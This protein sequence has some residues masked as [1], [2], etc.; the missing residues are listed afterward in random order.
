MTY[1][2]YLIGSKARGDDN[3]NSDIDYVCIYENKKPSLNIAGGSISY[4]SLS[5]MKWMIENSKLFVLHLIHEGEPLVEIEAHTE[6]LKKFSLNISILKNDHSE[7]VHAIQSLKWI[8][9]GPLG[10]R[11]G[12]DYAYTLARNIIFIENSIEGFY[13]FGYSTAVRYFLERKSL[14]HL[15]S[16][17]IDLR[18]EKYKYRNGS[19]KSARFDIEKLES[20]LSSLTGKSIVLTTGGKSKI[21]CKGKF[22]YRKLRML[23]RAI[24][25]KEIQDNHYLKLLQNHGEYFFSIRQ[26][27]YKLCHDLQKINRKNTLFK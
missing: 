27:A 17:F 14:L 20:V 5:R 21:Y 1:S 24:I 12:C 3:I 26:T 25:N 11:W 19:T 9:P 8:P 7:F 22:S 23:E 18:E 10:M 16:N 2:L 13:N 6:L 4:Y 15:I